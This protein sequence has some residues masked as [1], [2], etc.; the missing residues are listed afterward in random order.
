MSGFWLFLTVVFIVS[1]LSR[2]SCGRRRRY[3][4]YPD[5]A[6]NDPRDAEIDRLNERVRT[7][8]RIIT[9]S[10]W[11]LRRDIDGL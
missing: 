1:M 4:G 11:R 9:D 10:D 7:L 8:E 2:G 5:A 6:R 3:A